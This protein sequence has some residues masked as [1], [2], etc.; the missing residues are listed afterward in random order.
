[1]S[2]IIARSSSSCSTSGGSVPSSTSCLPALTIQKLAEPATN[3]IVDQMTTVQALAIKWY[4]I[5]TTVSGNKSRA[6]ELSSV[7]VNGTPVDS[8]YGIVGDKMLTTVSVSIVSGSYTL[9][10]DNQESEPV[11][12]YATRLYV[13]PSTVTKVDQNIVNIENNHALVPAN[14]TT[15]I[16]VISNE[17]NIGVKWLI[18]MIDSQKNRR[19]AQVFSLPD[20][21]KCAVYGMLG[22]S[23]KKT[24]IEVVNAAHTTSL[25]INNTLT[26]GISVDVVRIP[27]TPQLPAACDRTSD[28]DIWIP[29]YST[30]ITGATGVVDSQIPVPG[31]AAVKW[32]VVVT[33]GTSRQLFEIMADRYKVT[34]A[35]H[36]KYGMVGD[37]IDTNTTV[38]I[39]GMNLVL[40][41]TNN[42]PSTV[43]INTIRVPIA[44]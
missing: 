27:I 30:I 2:I 5:L 24:K 36:V 41:I 38:D 3:I 35:S 40:S 12:V 43:T 8:I 17:H 23:F 1:M 31:H 34:S 16:D 28:V 44:V 19:S 33:S 13:P 42:H 14:T 10:C 9:H 26:S 25:T 15:A 6:F 18:T 21:S 29:T 11:I 4:V 32:I 7:N 37:K 20:S 39:I 22:D